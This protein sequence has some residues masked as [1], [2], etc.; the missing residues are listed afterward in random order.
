MKGSWAALHEQLFRGI[1][2]R[3]DI[4][5]REEAGE[6]PRALSPFEKHRLL[7]EFTEFFPSEFAER[8]EKMSYVYGLMYCFENAVR[9]LVAQ[10]LEERKGKDWWNSVPE[11][12]RTYVASKKKEIEDNRWHEITI[13]ANIDYTLFGHLASIIQARWEEFDD[14]F[15][16]QT[17]IVQRL[18]ELERSRNVVMHGNVLAAA[19]IERVER[20]L[21]DWLR[22]V[23]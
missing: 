23:P 6:L 15:P 13:E 22:Q 5:R 2:L 16:S 3:E 18:E 1:L 19:E 9:D 21:N 11:R 17:W 20:Y 12:V 8:A 14:L 7:G 10:R 4:V